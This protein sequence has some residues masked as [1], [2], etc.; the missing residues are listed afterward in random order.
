MSRKTLK[1]IEASV[2]QRLLDI[3]R[4]TGT[5]YQRLLIRYAIERLLYRLSVSPYADKFILKGAMLFIT[6][7][8]AP[9]RETRDLDLLAAGVDDPST[10]NTIITSIIKQP[11]VN[12][13]LIFDETS[14]RINEIRE[15]DV[16]NGFRIIL[17][18]FI[19][20]A[21]IPIQIDLG[22]GDIVEPEAQMIN[23]PG[24]LDFPIAHL[25]AYP[26][27]TVIAE[28]LHAIVNLGIAN[29]RMKDYYDL[30]MILDQFQLNSKQLARAIT[31][32]FRRRETDIPT[33]IPLG[34]SDEF[35][36]DTGKQKLWRQFLKRH[37]LNA[38]TQDFATVVFWLRDRLVP[39]F[40]SINRIK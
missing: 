12:D 32:T 29:S 7:S 37:Q 22:F 26:P 30:F 40:K 9:F 14:I 39:I 10:L 25:R 16:Y 21:E 8:G 33:H 34:F 24:L 4:K 20:K 6:W 11:V 36:Q 2:R 1:N 15:Q 31:A 19:E 18:A 3:S 5:N 38:F 17:K 27:E 28:K 23:Y 35:A 13:G